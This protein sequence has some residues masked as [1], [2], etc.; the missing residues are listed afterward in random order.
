MV[1]N[2]NM[3]A[4]AVAAPLREGGGGEATDVYQDLLLTVFNPYRALHGNFHLDST[5]SYAAYLS[6]AFITFTDY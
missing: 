6:S 1:F 2:D 5:S 4:Q 3:V